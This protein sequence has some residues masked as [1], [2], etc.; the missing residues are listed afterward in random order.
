MTIR[1]IALGFYQEQSTAT[2]VISELERRHFS[3][4]AAIHC[5]HD[6][7]LEIYRYFL[8]S[9]IWAPLIGFVA[10]ISL[11]LLKFYHFVEF[12]WN[13]VW[14]T[15]AALSAITAIY[16]WW[17]LSR[18]LS[19]DII[20]RFK[21]RVLVNEI[22]IIVQVKPSDVREVLSILRN[23]KSGHPVTFLLRTSLYE[24]K[25]VEIPLEPLSME[26]L[27][28][29]ARELVIPLQEKGVNTG[30]IKNLKKRIRKCIT[31]LQFLRSDIADAEYIEQRIPPIS[32]VV[33]G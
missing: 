11:F 28:K 20:N 26:L 16:T 33:I 10:I 1:N 32:R 21:N 9:T 17:R 3:R 6:N 19:S 14:I 12:P 13:Q 5:K 27:C 2:A 31:M 7:S 22:L 30:N 29:Q 8:S 4:Y 18:V 24:E 23:V 25:F 15:I